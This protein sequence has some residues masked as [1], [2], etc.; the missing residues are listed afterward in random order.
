M[1]VKMKK[2]NLNILY[3]IINVDDGKMDTNIFP[4][5]RNIVYWSEKFETTAEQIEF[6]CYVFG[7]DEEEFKQEL[8]G[9]Q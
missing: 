4:I 8:E 1:G 9:Q 2:N 3:A 6:I 5:L 7:F